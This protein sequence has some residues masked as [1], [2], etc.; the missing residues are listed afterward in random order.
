MPSQAPTF[1]WGIPLIIIFG[2]KGSA[3]YAEASGY[4]SGYDPTRRRAKGFRGSKFRVQGLTQNE[5]R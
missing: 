2:F 4:A 3:A 1:K 5:E